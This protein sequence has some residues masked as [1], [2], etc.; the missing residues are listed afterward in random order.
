MDSH[1]ERFRS[2]LI[3]GG[4]VA[5]DLGADEAGQ[6]IPKRRFAA[7]CLRKK[8]DVFSCITSAREVAWKEKKVKSIKKVLEIGIRISNRE[9]G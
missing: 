1:P 3:W 7:A 6:D 9:Y 4:T 8:V 2:C 5:V